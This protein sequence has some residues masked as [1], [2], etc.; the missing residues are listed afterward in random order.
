MTKKLNVNVE[1]SLRF[2]ADGRLKPISKKEVADLK[3][4]VFVCRNCENEETI[5]KAQF[6]EEIICP[7]C[8]ALMSE[9]Q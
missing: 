1:E 8:G 2:K 6:A 7:K 4:K 9:R 5:E 3:N